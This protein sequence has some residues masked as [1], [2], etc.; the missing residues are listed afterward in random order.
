MNQ[1]TYKIIGELKMQGIDN[2][3]IQSQIAFEAWISS[4]PHIQELYIKNLC[5]LIFKKDGIII[6]AKFSKKE[7]LL[8]CLTYPILSIKK[9][10]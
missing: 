3:L 8:W 2:D 1:S 5:N 6:K 9:E 7:W 4:V 10:L